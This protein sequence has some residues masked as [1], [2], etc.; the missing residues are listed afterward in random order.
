MNRYLQL[1]QIAKRDLNMDDDIYRDLLQRVTGKRS[2]KGLSDRQLSKVLDEMKR[3][4]FKPKPTK[5]RK[6]TLTKAQAIE[7]SKM[8][9][10][11]I[12]MKKHGFIHDG[13]DQALNSFVYR[14]TGRL[15]K[16]GIKRVEWLTPS[17]AES[18]LEALKNWHKRSAIKV[19]I[20]HNI[21]IPLNATG[22]AYA[23]YDAVMSCYNAFL[24]RHE[25][26]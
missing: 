12:T 24:A 18:V 3:L 2:A 10:I 9:A 14:M 8:K 6:Q 22:T 26:Q 25:K 1:V 20:E 5:Q 4:G 16:L 17:L 21:D 7:V 15:N 11:W 13:S 19:M 23:G